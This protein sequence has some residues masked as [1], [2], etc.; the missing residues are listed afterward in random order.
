MANALENEI[1]GRGFDPRDFVLFLRRRRALP[2][3][4]VRGLARRRDDRRPRRGGL[5]LVGLRHLPGGH[6]LPARSLGRPDRAVRPGSRRRAPSPSSTRRPRAALGRARGRRRLRVPRYARMR[7]QWQRHELE[8]ASPTARSTPPRLEEVTAP[9]RRALH[10]TLR[11]GRAAARR[12]RGDRLDPAR[13]GDRDGLGQ[14]RPARG[15]RAARSSAR[16]TREVHF[17]RGAGAAPTPVFNGDAMPLGEVVEGPAVI[18]LRDHR[19]RRPARHQ[20]A[21]AATDRRLRHD[22]RTCR[23]DGGTMHR[24]R[25]RARGRAPQRRA[26]WDGTDHAFN[27]AGPVEVPPNL[28]LSTRGRAGDRPDHLR[29]GPP[30]PLERQRRARAGDREPRRLPDHGRDPRLPALHPHRG[31]RAPLLRPLPAVHVG[32]ARHDDPLHPR[33]PRGTGRA[34]ATCGSATTRSS[35]PPTSPTSA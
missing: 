23:G 3:R 4:R 10:R 21:S 1:I 16:G 13:A 34:T 20:R 27:P 12:P 8:C 11:R 26:F 5:G 15:R 2:R 35:A 24:D 29:G 31:R 19:D 32:D 6:P 14:P 22:A 7:F 28:K 25:D 17:E 9:V 30:L 33:T 18:D